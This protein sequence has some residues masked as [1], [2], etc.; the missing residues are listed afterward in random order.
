MDTLELARIAWQQGWNIIPLMPNEKKAAV[1]WEGYQD[2]KVSPST[3]KAWK[4]KLSEG[5]GIVCGPVSN[6]LVLDLDHQARKMLSELNY[7][8]PPTVQVYTG[9]GIHAYFTYDERITTTTGRIAKNLD[10]RSKGSY[11][12]GPGSRHPNGTIYE[13]IEGFEPWHTKVLDPPEWLFSEY[14]NLSSGMGKVAKEIGDT[15]GEGQ[16][17]DTMASLAGS[18]FYRGLPYS[19]VS[20]TIF[21]VNKQ[22]C[23]P[24]LSDDELEKVV[25][26]VSRYY[27][28]SN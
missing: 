11:V 25:W 12:V 26:S 5:Y 13:Y 19:I 23:D 20:A 24:P 18:L 15:I 7:S 10:I 16:R 4:S 9:A 8:L 28:G 17:N 27:G 21:A 6:L 3:L 14:E 1:K 22:M 2:E